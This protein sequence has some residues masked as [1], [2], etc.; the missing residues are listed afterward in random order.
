M[1]PLTQRI[2]NA[3]ISRSTNPTHALLNTVIEGDCVEVMR[4]L[5]DESI[6][7]VL[8]DPPYM[9]AYRPRDGRTIKNDDRSDWIIP[10]FQEIYRVLR[11][12]SFCMTFYGW[13]TVDLFF[14][15]F[16]SAGFRPV[17][18]VCF[19]KSYT[20][21]VGYTRGRHEVAYVLAKGRPSR[22]ADPPHDVIAWPYVEGD[23]HPTVK[24]ADCLVDFIEA[25]TKP[26]DIVLDPF[27]GSGTTL[28]AAKLWDRNYIGIEIDAGYA[29]LARE[30]VT[31]STLFDYRQAERGTKV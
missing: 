27:C 4:R 8:T 1:K 15:A 9:T 14:S 23:L 31:R 25:Y 10:A 20:S 17:S 2:R 29:K 16:R 12:D 3:F 21:R 30:E 22:P 6:D 26:G 13:P 11:P 28:L 5:P 18:H 24:P 19:L 7:F